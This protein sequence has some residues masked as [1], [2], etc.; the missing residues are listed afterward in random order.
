MSDLGAR[1]DRH[2]CGTERSVLPLG[3]E[4]RGGGAGVQ[5]SPGPTLHSHTHR[6]AWALRGR[7]VGAAWALLGRCSGALNV[8][9]Y[10]EF[11]TLALAQP[12]EAELP[13]SHDLASADE[14]V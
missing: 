4:W 1:K 12:D 2:T 9:R 7:C 13:T 10:G 14:H 8:R 3:V 6:T 5:S 11:G